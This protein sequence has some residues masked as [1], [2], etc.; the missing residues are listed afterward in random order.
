MDVLTGIGLLAGV[1]TTI[2]FIPQMWRIHR[3]K[4]T[5]DLSLWAYV[6]LSVGLFLWVIYGV[7]DRAIAIVLPNVL[8]WIMSFYIIMMKI[9]HG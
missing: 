8:V 1:C 9:K 2:S 7:M 5:R 4:Q 3:T 6:L